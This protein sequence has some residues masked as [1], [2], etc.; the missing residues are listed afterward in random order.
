M[1]HSFVLLSLFRAI[2][3]LSSEI[4]DMNITQAMKTR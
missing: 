4:D 3:F 1:S 2:N